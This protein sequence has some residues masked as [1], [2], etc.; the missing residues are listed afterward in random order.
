VSA[1]PLVDRTTVRATG[2]R[3][4]AGA[5]VLVA[6][7]VAALLVAGTGPAVAA[8]SAASDEPAAVADAH[9]SGDPETVVFVDGSTVDEHAPPRLGAA[10]L[11]PSRTA[12]TAVPAPPQPAPA[13][14]PGLPTAVEPLQP[15]VSAAS[16]DPRD[17]VGT[18]AL[19]ALLKATYPGTTYGVA[20][21]CGTD[22]LRTSEHYEGRA[23][24][25]MTNVRDPLGAARAKAVLDWLLATDGA[26]NPYANARRL[27]VMYLIW[28]NRIW[29][30]YNPAAGW[31]P[32]STCAVHP[33]PSWD[34]TCHRDH[35]HVSL[36]WAGAQRRT[37][38]WTKAVVA[39]DYGP[40][41]PS[42]LNWAAPYSAPRATRCP[43]YPLVVAPAGSS[44][45]LRQ[46]TTYSGIRLTTG[47]TGPVVTA[48]QKVVGATPDGDYGPLTAAAV[49]TFQTAH[50]V[51][52][53]GVVDAPTWRAILA[54]VAA[55]VSGG[56]AT[57]APTPTPAPAPKPKP[58]PKPEPAPAPKRPVLKV[59]SKGPWVRTVQKALHVTQD[60]L[61]GP[62]TRRAVMTY[63]RAKK[64]PVTGVVGPLTW[65]ALGI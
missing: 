7:L 13:T 3:G 8:G 52:A 12:S 27:G 9:P 33:D 47:M 63:Q 26:G 46:L 10:A 35:I 2:R 45:Q 21:T 59:G 18:A 4:A 39:P 11:G 64:L 43:S 60:G 65:K 53:S 62:Q 19:G 34:T 6:A 29:G 51:P 17:K 28:N 54:A 16:C 38:F 14:P 31:R 20:R 55:P 32:Y 25:W 5:P 58:K 23:V 22:P 41:R 50:A 48:V 56:P 40:C 30:A 49:R 57:P 61:F 15:Y 37:S 1:R 36:G 44:A 24:D 42:D